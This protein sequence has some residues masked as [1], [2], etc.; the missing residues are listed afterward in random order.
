MRTQAL[1]LA[2]LVPVSLRLAASGRVIK[3]PSLSSP[4]LLDEMDDPTH[5]RI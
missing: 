5:L 4:L 1:C 3:T 2:I